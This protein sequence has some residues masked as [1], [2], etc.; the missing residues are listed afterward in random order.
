MPAR[1]DTAVAVVPRSAWRRQ[2]HPAARQ[3]VR[4]AAALGL[5]ASFR[6]TRYRRVVPQWQETE[7]LEARL[8]TPVTHPSARD[9]F[10]TLRAPTTRAWARESHESER[11]Y[12]GFG[13]PR[14]SDRH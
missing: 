13:K 2:H 3:R 7:L 4:M 14:L 8:A 1:L 11:T 5:P 9:A 12:H 10:R 6:V